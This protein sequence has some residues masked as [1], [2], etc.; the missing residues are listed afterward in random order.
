MTDGRGKK[1][2]LQHMLQR[3][4][5]YSSVNGLLHYP[6]MASIFWSSSSVKAGPFRAA[7]FSTIC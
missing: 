7:T 2:A 5:G 6:R 4:L 3:L 1:E